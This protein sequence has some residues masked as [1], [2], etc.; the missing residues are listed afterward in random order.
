MLSLSSFHTE[1]IDWPRKRQQS[2]NPRQLMTMQTEIYVYLILTNTNKCT[3]GHTSISNNVLV[4]KDKSEWRKQSIR[5]MDIIT[6]LNIL[7]SH[8]YSSYWRFMQAFS[9]TPNV[10]LLV[11]SVIHSSLMYTSDTVMTWI[12][13]I[14]FFLFFLI[15]LKRET[16]R[17]RK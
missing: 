4:I 13:F 7:N 15:C 5:S 17:S 16:N 8:T 6:F 14:C 1:T 12:C 11:P 9:S 2:I 10:L 3:A